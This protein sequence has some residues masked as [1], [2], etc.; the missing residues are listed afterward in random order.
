MKISGYL[1]KKWLEFQ[2]FGS[3]PVLEENREMLAGSTIIAR[4]LGEKYRIA[5]SSSWENAEISNCVGII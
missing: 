5:G 4:Y 1:K 2:P 3:V